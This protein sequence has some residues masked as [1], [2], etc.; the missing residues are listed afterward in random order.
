MSSGQLNS[1]EG[2]A[3]ILRGP[4]HAGA[5]VLVTLNSPREKFWGTILELTTAGLSIR[6][7]DL[8]SFEDFARMLH[9]GE[10]VTPSTV[11]FPMGRIERMEMDVRNGEIPSLSERF[12]QKTGREA[13]EVLAGALTD[14]EAEGA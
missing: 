5:V 8:N 4:F 10:M 7:I 1:G 14:R 3:P 9:A 2:P 12:T 11:F 6:G 13:H